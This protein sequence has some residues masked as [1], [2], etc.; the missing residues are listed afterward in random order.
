MKNAL[1]QIKQSAHDL[2][3]VLSKPA[4]KSGFDK[5]VKDI[6]EAISLLNSARRRI[7]SKI[8]EAEQDD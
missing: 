7:K 4:L 1:K 2:E 3:Q 8:K 5:E 6:E